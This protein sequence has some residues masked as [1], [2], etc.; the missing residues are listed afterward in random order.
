MGNS[1][2]RHK[3]K[4]SRLAQ[5]GRPGTKLHKDLGQRSARASHSDDK[6]E[7]DDKDHLAEQAKR[8]ART[9]NYVYSF[10]QSKH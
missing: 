9:K 7:V 5:D 4:V 3:Q 8:Y 10:I 6:C 2:V 1:R